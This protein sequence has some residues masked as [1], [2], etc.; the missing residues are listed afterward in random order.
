MKKVTIDTNLIIDVEEKREGYK[1]II[2]IFNLANQNLIEIY[3][4]APIANEKS[5]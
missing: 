4:P 1:E 5:F 2:K 3:F